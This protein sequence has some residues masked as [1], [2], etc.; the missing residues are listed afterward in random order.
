M[1][2]RSR[3]LLVAGLVVAFAL[4]A[5]LA[6]RYA[7]PGGGAT[8]ASTPAAAQ[9]A[10]GGA[11]GA[12]ELAVVQL[13]ELEAAPPEIAE[14]G[15]DVFR[16]RPQAPPPR[17]GPGPG[18]PAALRPAPT[19]P[20]AA[21]PAGPPPIDLKFIGLIDAPAQG[22]QVAVLS[23]GR[24][25][26]YGHEGDTIDGRYRIVRIGLESIEMARL[27]GDDRQTIRLTGE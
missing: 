26:F 7:R 25:V 23:N 22:G 20:A 13:E 5:A 17:P 12:L 19:P 24:F 15:R 6:M 18:G 9:A 21:R 14:G 16:F 3:L 27:D 1:A 10:G 8:A 4:V 11:G 2:G